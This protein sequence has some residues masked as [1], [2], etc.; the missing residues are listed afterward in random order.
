MQNETTQMWSKT[1][2]FRDDPYIV[3]NAKSNIL[4]LYGGT[5]EMTPISC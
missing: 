3:L 4:K 5:I 2:N 1:I